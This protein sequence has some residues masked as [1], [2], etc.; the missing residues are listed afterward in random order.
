MN[1]E[2]RLR[3][4]EKQAAAKQEE[5]WTLFQINYYPLQRGN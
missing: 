5:D 4:L 1:V 3:K 2:I